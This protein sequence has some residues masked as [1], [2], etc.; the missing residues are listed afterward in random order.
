MTCKLRNWK[1]FSSRGHQALLLVAASALLSGTANAQQIYGLRGPDSAAV[2]AAVNAGV[3]G[4]GTDGK[5][6]NSLAAVYHEHQKHNKKGTKSQYISAVVAANTMGDKVAIDA[7]ATGDVN[8]L[9]SDLDALG[10]E[11]GATAGRLVSGWL[12]IDAIDEASALATL[13]SASMASYISNVGLTTSQGDKAERSDLARSYGSG[14]DGT[15]IT[16]G[17][18]SDSYNSLGTAPADVT[19]GDLPAGVVVVADNGT[20]DEGRAM[21]QIIHDVAPGA[22]LQFATANGG[23]AVFAANILALDTNG[24]DVINDDITYF[25]EPMFQDGVIAQAIDQVVANGTAYFSSAGN[26]ANRS[27]DSA[28]NPSAI[29]T[30]GATNVGTLHDFDPGP[31]VDTFQSITVAAGGTGLIILQWDQPFAS[32]GGATC[33]SNVNFYLT[34]TAGTSILLS[35]TTNNIGGDAAEFLGFTNG[36]ASPASAS[37]AISLAAGPAPGRI[38]YIDFRSQVTF[39]EFFTTGSTI[40][41]HHNAASDGTCGAAFYFRTPP[42]G[43]APPLL[44]SFSSIGGTPILF[45]SAGLAI[46]P[47]DRQKPNFVAPDGV[48]TTFFGNDIADPGD[49]SDADTFKNFFGTSAAAP[50]AA[51]VAALMLEAAGGPGSMTPAQVRQRLA[52]TAIPMPPG[53][54]SSGAG[55]INAEAAIEDEDNIAPAV[56]EAVPSH[57]SS[58]IQPT[59]DGNGDNLRDAFQREVSSFPNA[60]NGEYITLAAATGLQ[61][62]GVVATPPLPTPPAGE[63]FPVGIV[64]FVLTA[65]TSPLNAFPALNLVQMILQT[66]P[67][68]VITSHWKYDSVAGTYFAFNAPVTPFGSGALYDGDRTITLRLVDDSGASSPA[69]TGDFSPLPGIILDPSGPSSSDPLLVSLT[70]F[71]ATPRADASGVDLAWTTTA[72]VDNVGFNVYRLTDNQVGAKINA[73]FIPAAGVDGAGASYQLLDEADL[74]NG[75]IRGYYLEDIDLNG[76]RTLHGPFTTS[77][78]AAVPGWMMY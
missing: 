11:G 65:G 31:G 5:I 37:L 35:S 29:T 43:T 24:C 66:K 41:G 77:G 78:S 72:E 48:N 9:K 19:S 69:L 34:N 4:V 20:T 32:V 46:S 26:A 75:E 28:W 64:E 10:L 15:G 47:V 33:A 30:I 16:V 23:Q 76:T 74:A 50:H 6:A 57:P 40:Y 7:I 73:S 18:L 67:N 63:A 58:S 27:Y 62:S 56:E 61:I 12:P 2:Q 49:G 54:T 1:R 39:N 8:Q 55:L 52:D 22:A 25:A 51:G 17:T 14:L 60:V 53:G 45:D 71:T 42:F 3:D 59:G 13:H 21:M 68:P 36:G 44:E 38:K 70:S